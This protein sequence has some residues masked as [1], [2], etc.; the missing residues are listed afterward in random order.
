MMANSNASSQ[1]AIE[2]FEI[3]TSRCVFDV[4]PGIPESYIGP[5]LF[6]P[7]LKFLFIQSFIIVVQ[8]SELHIIGEG[9]SRDETDDTET[10]AN[11]LRLRYDFSPDSSHFAFIS[12]LSA[13][14]GGKVQLQIWS[15]APDRKSFNPFR[16]PDKLDSS[17]SSCILNE[18]DAAGFD[19][20]PQSTA[21]ILSLWRKA[22]SSG[23]PKSKHYTMTSF[24]LDLK[25]AELNELEPISKKSAQVFGRRC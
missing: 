14:D 25:S 22:V 11:K 7:D 24:I 19:F 17:S 20:H 6:S 23:A 18:Y 9:I 16:L 8:S 10:P 3:D 1:A 2:I 4:V 5:Y 12:Y 21:I 15:L 13:L